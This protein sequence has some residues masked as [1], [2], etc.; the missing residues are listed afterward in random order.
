MKAQFSGRGAAASL[1][2]LSPLALAAPNGLTLEERMA[3]LESRVVAAESRAA[4]AEA[5]VI[6]LRQ[7]EQA[8]PAKPGKTATT[9]TTASNAAT[10]AGSAATATDQLSL[11]ERVARIEAQ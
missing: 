9:A 1:L 4:K 2:L 3:Q 10:S 5:E 8:K 6:R 11:D 7:E